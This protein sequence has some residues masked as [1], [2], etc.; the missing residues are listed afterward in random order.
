M[1]ERNG[2]GTERERSDIGATVELKGS[3]VTNVRFSLRV[4]EGWVL[5]TSQQ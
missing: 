5:F 1:S 2:V 3:E 4:N